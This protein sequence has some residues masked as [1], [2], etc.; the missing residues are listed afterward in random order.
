MVLKLSLYNLALLITDYF[1][2]TVFQIS[3][4]LKN[5]PKT[6]PRT[7]LKK[8]THFSSVESYSEVQCC[9]YSEMQILCFYK[10]TFYLALCLHL[11]RKLKSTVFYPECIFF[12]Y[13]NSESRT[14]QHVHASKCHAKNKTKQ[15]NTR[16]E[17]FCLHLFPHLSQLPFLFS[18]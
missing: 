18:E 15:K 7:H 16:T 12:F 5:P 14:V 1:C 2:G 9:Y 6:K 13:Q 17:I 4:E 10:S 3:E 8:T 11:V